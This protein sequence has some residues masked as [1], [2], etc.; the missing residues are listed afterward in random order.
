MQE[1][2]EKTVPTRPEWSRNAPSLPV[3]AQT[4]ALGPIGPPRTAP[5]QSHFG[6]I[7][8]QNIHFDLLKKSNDFG[9][10]FEGPVGIILAHFRCQIRPKSSPGAE[11]AVL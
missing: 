7:A 10:G 2:V 8:A 9:A 1:D 3:A 5:F 6:T 4:G 11:S